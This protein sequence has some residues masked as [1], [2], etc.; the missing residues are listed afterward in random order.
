MVLLETDS[1]VKLNNSKSCYVFVLF[2]F[3][4]FHILRCADE[5]K[6]N[7]TER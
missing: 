4:F 3:V 7:K 5:K 6:D 1:K 2:C